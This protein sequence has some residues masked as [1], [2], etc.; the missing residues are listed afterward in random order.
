MKNRTSVLKKLTRGVKVGSI[1]GI[2]MGIL[3]FPL[4]YYLLAVKYRNE[5]SEVL[6]IAYSPRVQG[7]TMIAIA[8]AIILAT[9]GIL[10]VLFYRKLLG[11]TPFQKAFPFGL[12]I[13]ILSRVGDMIVDYP[14]SHGL[15]LDNALFSAPLLLFF[16]PYLVSRLYRGE[17]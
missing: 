6:G 17:P 3:S 1:S 14:M 15:V 10:Y 4:N 8:T 9:C 5:I 7:L 2:I 16:Y 12:G 11:S 13:F